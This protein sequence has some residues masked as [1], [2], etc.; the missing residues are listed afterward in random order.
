[1]LR[2][3]LSFPFPY[4]VLIRYSLRLLITIASNPQLLRELLLYI[5]LE[6]S[7]IQAKLF[8]PHRPLIYFKK[9]IQ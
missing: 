2:L 9:Q 1:M 5:S 8:Q 4:F 3:S 7:L 6:T